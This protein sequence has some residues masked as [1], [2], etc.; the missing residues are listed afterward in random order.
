MKLSFLFFS[1]AQVVQKF[2]LKSIFVSFYIS[3]WNCI[4]IYLKLQKN[5]LTRAVLFEKYLFCEKF[6]AITIMLQKLCEWKGSFCFIQRGFCFFSKFLFNDTELVN[7][8]IDNLNYVVLSRVHS[9][10]IPW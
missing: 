1:F 5:A 4:K 8:K 7:T 10:K 3:V 2:Y 9:G 6:A